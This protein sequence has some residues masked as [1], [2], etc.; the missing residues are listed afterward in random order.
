MKISIFGLG[1]VG[2]VTMGCLSRN[3]HHVIGVD[4]NEEKVAALRKGTS[5][6]VEPGLAEA[7]AE[8]QAAGRLDAVTDHDDAI[9]RSDVSI[10]CV[11]TPSRDNG[12]LDLQYVETVAGQIAESLRG[13][14]KHHTLIFRS[15][16]LPGST[17]GLAEGLLRDL[18]EAGR[19]TVCFYPEFLREGTAVRDFEHPSIAAL[20][21]R[22]GC[23]VPEELA[24][25]VGDDIAIVT[26]ESA[27]LLKYA[28]N[29]FHAVKVAFANEIGRVG[30]KAGLNAAA[31]MELF[32]RDTVLNL[33][34]YYLRP[35]N[36]FGGSCLPKDVRALNRFAVQSGLS[37]PLIGSLMQSNR[38]HADALQ[39]V[40]RRTG[41]GDV[42]IIGLAF[43]HNTDD[44]RESPMVDVVRDL[45]P[46]GR[47]VRI[48]DPALKPEKLTGSNRAQIR[49]KLP[50]FTDLLCNRLDEA[51]GPAELVVAAHPCVG[52]DE[53]RT[54]ITSRHI[55]LDVNGWPA[56]KELPSR[57]D[58]FLW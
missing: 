38:D 41:S 47:K 29:S 3:G 20:G 5:P 21:T 36:P 12:D 7:I 32:C 56:L 26:W 11:G 40:I 33:S 10:V 46:S 2:A 43:K 35:G 16:M 44:L 25:L 13:L 14:D 34:P 37:T 27:E 22:D 17:R 18:V 50:G 58:G 42:A 15:T 31:V 55:V 4:V 19:L 23:T 54:C 30:K 51:V 39:R 1:Y 24:E 6:I 53:L 8:G 48:Y 28:C 9:R 57:Y 52:I 45:I 49:E